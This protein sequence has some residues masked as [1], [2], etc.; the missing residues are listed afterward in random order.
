MIAAIPGGSQGSEGESGGPRGKA[1]KARHG[2]T[3]GQSWPASSD[4]E[5]GQGDASEPTRHRAGTENVRGIIETCVE[6]GVRILTLYAFSTENWQRPYE[7]IGP[8]HRVP[9]DEIGITKVL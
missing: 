1:A 8:I 2:K 6:V 7:E 4:C 5:Q 3:S 9:D